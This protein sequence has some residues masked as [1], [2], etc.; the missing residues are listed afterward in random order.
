[1]TFVKTNRWYWLGALAIAVAIVGLVAASAN[2]DAPV[3]GTWEQSDQKL[4]HFAT[5][6]DPIE[7]ISVT[8]RATGFDPTELKPHGRKFLFSLDNRTEVKELVLKLSRGDGTQVKELRVPGNAG[9]WSELFELKPGA[10]SLTEI[11]HPN[12][13]CTIIVR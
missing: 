9:D 10:Y 3:N 12:S 4:G 2:N 5:Y 7:E 1:M 8:L 11:N 6:Q 13:L